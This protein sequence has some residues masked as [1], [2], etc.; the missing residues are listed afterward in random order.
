MAVTAESWT[1][2][3]F[4]AFITDDDFSVAIILDN[5][6]TSRAIRGS[7]TGRRQAEVFN[8]YESYEGTVW[9]S[10][11]DFP[12]LKDTGGTITVDRIEYEVVGVFR[13][14]LNAILRI[15]YGDRYAA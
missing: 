11:A 14:A 13:D 2:E 9:V 15:D 7:L 6:A 12:N 8:L 3:T 4:E 1:I 10:N 5:K